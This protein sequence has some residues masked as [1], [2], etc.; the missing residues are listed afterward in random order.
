MEPTRFTDSA[1]ELRTSGTRAE[2]DIPKMHKF[3]NDR[4]IKVLWET[5]F[6]C[7][8]RNS[9]T[10]APDSSCKICHGRG[11]G[12]LPAKEELLII[13]SQ[14]KGMSNMDLGLYDSGTAIATTLPEAVVS[15]RDRVTLPE[16][17]I[18]HSMIFDVTRR[19]VDKGMWLSY[20]VKKITLALTDNAEVLHEIDDYTIDIEK[21]TIYPR[22][23]LMGQNLSLNIVSTLRY[24]VID[25]LKESRYQY[26]NKGTELEKFSSLPKKLLLKREDAWVNPTP[27]S[28][29]DDVETEVNGESVEDPKRKMST[30]GF[31]GG[32]LS[33]G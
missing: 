6:L 8:C 7:P 21:N 31:F 22:E 1:P 2:F 9:M 30:G 4:S 26:T 3:V 29:N 12:Y 24:I 15:F 27:F 28:L 16:V 11:I 14:E 17:E 13:Q 18:T 10:G 23:H 32:E 20:D 33:G 5:S 19:R 25:L